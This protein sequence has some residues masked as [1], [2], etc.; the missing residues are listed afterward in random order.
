MFRVIVFL[1]MDVQ[2]VTFDKTI[3]LAHAGDFLLGFRPDLESRPPL[4]NH[5]GE[6][7]A[8]SILGVIPDFADSNIRFLQQR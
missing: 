8:A 5:S 6:H 1:N 7:R 4:K 3:K 2:V